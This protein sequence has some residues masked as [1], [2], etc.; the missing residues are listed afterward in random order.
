MAADGRRHAAEADAASRSRTAA[1][2]GLTIRRATW[3]ACTVCCL[4]V[5]DYVRGH[6][7][8]MTAFYA[9]NVAVYL[10]NE[11]TRAFCGNLAT[12]PAARDAWFIE[13]DAAGQRETEGLRRIP[14]AVQSRAGCQPDRDADGPA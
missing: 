12:L 4:A 2:G 5:G 13:S 3:F 11:Q 14:S 7:D 9:S 8:V 10:T 1:L 6:S